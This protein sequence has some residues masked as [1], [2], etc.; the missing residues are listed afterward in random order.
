MLLLSNAVLRPNV[1]HVHVCPDSV[2]CTCYL[3][4]ARSLN[5]GLI[6]WGGGN[7]MHVLPQSLTCIYFVALV[8]ELATGML[9][10]WRNFIITRLQLRK[11]VQ[12]LKCTISVCY[13]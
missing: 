1:I 13:H 5:V 12:L 11:G 7:R 4:C 3:K 10:V 2:D 6:W 8:L 9:Y